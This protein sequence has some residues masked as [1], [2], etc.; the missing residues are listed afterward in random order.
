MQ[1]KEIRY[2][3][4]FNFEFLDQVD[5]VLDKI[6]IIHKSFDQQVSYVI[7]LNESLANKI[8][9]TLYLI[10]AKQIKIEN[11]SN[12]FSTNEQEVGTDKP[13]GSK[14]AIDEN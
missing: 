8:I 2:R 6:K 13:I 14:A 1:E 4:T 10:T 11:I 7:S 5:L 3:I 12:S 9:Y